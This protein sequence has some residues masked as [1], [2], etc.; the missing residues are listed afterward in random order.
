MSSMLLLLPLC[1]TAFSDDL[2]ATQRAISA[3][4]PATSLGENTSSYIRDYL[5][6]PRRTG[7]LAGSILGG[8]LSAHPAGPVLGS[9]VGFFIGKQSMFNEDKTRDLKAG[10]L[11]TKRDIV[12][13]NG[14]ATPTLSLANTQRITFDAPDTGGGTQV[15]M[16]SPAING[17]SRAQI[18]A[19]C[20]GGANV[21]PRFR[22]LCFYSSGS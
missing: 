15:L 2:L 13:Q 22:A 10:L 1:G 21:D 18:V 8:A 4:S 7:S 20:A 16:S 17:L 14:Q 3:L 6:D 5:S 11:Y 19:M 12:P 9:L